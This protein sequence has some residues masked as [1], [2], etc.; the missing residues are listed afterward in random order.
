MEKRLAVIW[1]SEL[2]QPVGSPC[3]I[4]TTFAEAGGTSF[5]LRRLLNHVEREQGVQGVIW[6][7]ESKFI[8]RGSDGLR[9]CRRRRG[10]AVLA[11][12]NV[13]QRVRRGLGSGKVTVWGCITKDGVG[14]LHRINGRMD[15]W[16]YIDILEVCVY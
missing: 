11:P 10:H 14:R 13:S 4:H 2:N 16:M 6:S 12:R 7:D 5:N 8:L 3:S 15:R 9:W 1:Q